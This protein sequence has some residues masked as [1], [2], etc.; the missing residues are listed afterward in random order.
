MFTTL[1]IVS[2]LSFSEDV[3]YNYI[4]SHATQSIAMVYATDI[5]FGCIKVGIGNWSKNSTFWKDCVSGGASGTA[6]FVGTVIASK[7]DIF[8]MG[9][10]GKFIHDLGVSTQDNMMQNKNLF[11]RYR[12]DVGLFGITF[13][14]SSISNIDISFYSVGGL[15]LVLYQGQKFQ[16]K[17]S[18]SNFTPIFLKSNYD[19]WSNDIVNGFSVGNII[20]YTK[21]KN[22]D[23][24][25]KKSVLSHEMI[26]TL[27]YGRTRFCGDYINGPK[28]AK[29]F[30]IGQDS[31]YGLSIGMSQ[32]KKT[33]HHSPTELEAYTMENNP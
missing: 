31:C 3:G 28:W 6:V 13:E 17:K 27:Q 30:K 32:F 16:L 19:T 8:G 23:E 24:N 2:L 14:N 22:E 1:L 11:S 7:N 29:Y 20:S 15:V 18:I 33:Y 21:M 12:T 4:K 5:V 26:H 9:A 25:G 10:L